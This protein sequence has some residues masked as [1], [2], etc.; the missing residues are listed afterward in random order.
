VTSRHPDIPTGVDGLVAAIDR[1]EQARDELRETVREAHSSTKALR[2]VE[3]DVRQALAELDD[4]IEAVVQDRIQAAIDAKVAEACELLSAE[5]DRNV[6]A[7]RAEFRAVADDLWRDSK[8]VDLRDLIGE[9]R[10]ALTVGGVVTLGSIP[11]LGP[12]RLPTSR[13]PDIPTSPGGSS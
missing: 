6:E 10:K 9:W 11:G 7:L 2:Q 4:R 13:H 12:A 5:I 3:R 1:F 8:G